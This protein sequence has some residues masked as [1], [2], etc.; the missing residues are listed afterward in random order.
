[1]DKTKKMA[2]L[3]PSDEAYLSRRLKMISSLH[4]YLILLESYAVLNHVGF[5]KILKK[6]DKLTGFDTTEKYM[7]KEVGKKMFSNHLWIRDALF[8]L[9]EEFQAIK[10]QAS[11]VV[12]KS[13]SST[14][15][16]AKNPQRGKRKREEISDFTQHQQQYLQ[17]FKHHQEQY[18]LMEETT[19]FYIKKQ[20]QK[21]RKR[22]GKKLTPKPKQQDIQPNNT[23]TEEKVGNLEF[24]Q[25]SASRKEEARIALESLALAAET[26][27]LL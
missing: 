21:K 23:V 10:K 18:G 22:K 14:E 15:S 5:R 9:E 20:K 4:L 17:E 1:M 26:H 16:E 19:N 25:L 2:E 24:D 12:T 8:S 6:H 11:S 27:L 13:I 3:V 7:E